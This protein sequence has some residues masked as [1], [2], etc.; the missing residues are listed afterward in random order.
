MVVAAMIG[1]LMLGNER[2]QGAVIPSAVEKDRWDPA[3]RPGAKTP[4]LAPTLTTAVLPIHGDDDSAIPSEESRTAAAVRQ[5][6]GV[7]LRLHQLPGV[8]R[9]VSSEGARLA[10][11]FLVQFDRSGGAEACAGP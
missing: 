8:D 4:P 11:D 7:Q 3:S 1:I 2:W 5:G 9:C 6:Y 10:R